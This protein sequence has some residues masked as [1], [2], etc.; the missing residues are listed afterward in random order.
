M[1]TVYSVQKT[2]WDQNVPKEMIQPNEHAGR[3][4][5]SY[6]TYEASAEQSDIQMFNIPDGARLL[7]GEVSYDALGASTTISVG[8]G[9][10]TDSSGS[11]VSA[12]VAAYKAAAAST[13]AGTVACLDTLALGKY[14]EVDADEEGLPVTVSLAGANGTGTI[15]CWIQW[16]LD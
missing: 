15:S 13:S 8:Y 6:A 3:V 5:C 4:R 7:A 11:A 9:A 14:A 2:K 16:V 1:A 10:Y 12:S